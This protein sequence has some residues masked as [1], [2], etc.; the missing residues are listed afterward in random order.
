MLPIKLYC[1]FTEFLSAGN[2]YKNMHIL[3][4]V[5]YTKI[6]WGRNKV[7]GRVRTKI[8]C[9]RAARDT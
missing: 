7:W 2:V 3:N 6:C 9:A 1:K 8:C 4:I 5:T